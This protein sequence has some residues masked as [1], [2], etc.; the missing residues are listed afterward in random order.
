MTDPR[1]TTLLQAALQGTASSR[2]PRDAALAVL[3]VCVEHLHADGGCVYLL[4]LRTTRYIPFVP[5]HGYEPVLGQP[6]RR[7]LPE[8]GL[9]S[10]SG[11]APT[12]DRPDEGTV[13][14][15]FRGQSCVAALRLDGID[16]KAIPAEMGDDLRAS[17]NL[18]V[19]VYEDEF[20]FNLLDTIQVPLDFAQSDD[21]FFNEIAALIELSSG[22]EFVALREHQAGVLRCLALGGFGEDPDP[23]DWDLSP[24]DRYTPFAAA[25]AGK[26]VAVPDMG[27]PDM[28]EVRARPWAREL[29]SCV[30]VPVRVGTEIFGVLSLAARCRFDYA[31]LEI[32]GFESIANGVG[33]SIANFRNSRRLRAHVSEY[34]E[35]AVAISAI[36]VARIARHEATG[37]VDTAQLGLAALWRKL[38]KPSQMANDF[39]KVSD[40]LLEVNGA[41]LKIKYAT[42]PPA[43]EWRLVSLRT[44]WT[45]AQDALAERLRLEKID[46][47][48]V[49]PDVDVLAQPDWLQQVFLNLLLNSVDAFREGNRGNRRIELNVARPSP[50]AR[51][52]EMTYRDNATGVNPQRLHVP[53]D[54]AERPIQQQLFEAGVTSKKEGSGLGLWLV[55]HILGDHF[56][57]IDLADHRQGITFVIRIL[58]PAE[59]AVLLEASR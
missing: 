36:E 25:L 2:T 34:A 58:K 10:L 30:A 31:P 57:S 16:P 44:V 47:Q 3:N 17:A 23:R 24:V 14:Y 18:L 38:D 6:D 39:E 52:I 8:D 33:V 55:R 35:A 51:N 27:I 40:D 7:G 22:M 13:V 5:R 26:A 32:R 46:V 29:R 11:F 28:A 53:A 41:L 19:S 49:G 12:P 45:S 56:G 50:R 9:G 37:R 1:P 21:Q 20:A 59:V 43:S 42:K 4:D 48:F 15:S 54:Y